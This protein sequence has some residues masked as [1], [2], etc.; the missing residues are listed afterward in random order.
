M[1]GLF[2]EHSDAVDAHVEREGV[3]DVQRIVVQVKRGQ[4]RDAAANAP[5]AAG[6]PLSCR[7]VLLAP[8]SER[9]ALGGVK[10]LERVWEERGARQLGEEVDDGQR[11]FLKTTVTTRLNSLFLLQNKTIR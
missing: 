8:A 2:E 1:D 10:T 4:C 9:G 7:L 11:H 3:E 6:Q 5:D